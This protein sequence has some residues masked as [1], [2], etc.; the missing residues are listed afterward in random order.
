MSAL[1]TIVETWPPTSNNLFVVEL[2]SVKIFVVLVPIF[3]RLPP[4]GAEALGLT[5]IANVSLLI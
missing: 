3:A 4:V 2:T 5:L 1:S